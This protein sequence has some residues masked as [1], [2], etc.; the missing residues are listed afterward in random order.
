MPLKGITADECVSAFVQHWVSTFGCPEHIYTDRGRQF[1]SGAWLSMCRHLGSNAHQSTSYHPQAQGTVERLNRTLK[2]SLKCQEDASQWFNHLPWVLL[3]L[4]NTP[5]E[6][7]SDSTPSELVFGQPVRLPGEF[8]DES[9]EPNNPD[10][11]FSDNLAAFIRSI[12]FSPARASKRPSYIDPKLLDI[13]TTHVYVRID[14][15]QPPLYPS[16]MGPY[17]IVNRNRKYFE[18]NMRT[19]AERVSIDRLKPAYLSVDTLNQS[20]GQQIPSSFSSPD[21]VELR[22]LKADPP[23]QSSTSSQVFT[24]RGRRVNPPIRFADYETDF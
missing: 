2:T 15:R 1:L 21:P 16:Y 13:A 3:A 22:S 19:H 8:F 9:N 20:V 14:K 6:D 23:H 12:K 18:L 7:L 17:Q 4:R 24:R 5:K 11:N 10:C